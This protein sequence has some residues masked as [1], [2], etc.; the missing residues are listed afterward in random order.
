MRDGPLLRD[1]SIFHLLEDP[2]GGVR[3]LLS[4]C[5]LLLRV[6]PRWPLS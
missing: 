1:L 3:R 5:Y 2:D 4:I 6:L